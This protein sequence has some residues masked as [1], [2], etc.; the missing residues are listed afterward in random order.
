MFCQL[1]LSWLLWKIARTEFNIHN[2]D[3]NLEKIEYC[4][5]TTINDQ[6]QLRDFVNTRGRNFTFEKSI[7]VL[8]QEF[9]IY[10]LINSS[11]FKN[12][13]HS[14]QVNINTSSTSTVDTTLKR[15]NLLSQCFDSEVNVTSQSSD[16]Y[17]GIND[18]LA[19]DFSHTGSDNDSS[20]DID[21]LL[22]R[23]QQHSFPILSS[24]AKVV[25]AI[26]AS[27]TT[28]ERLSSTAKNVVTEK[29]TRLHCEKINQM[30]FLQKNMNILKELLNSDFRRKRT[31]SMSSTTTVS[32]EESTC[33]V[34]KQLCLDVVDSFNDANKENILD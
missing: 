12:T 34:P 16:P 32:S 28:I 20:D 25:C 23:Q 26:P 7:N 17:Q 11:S 31:A 22:W 6:S 1:L 5:G 9:E 4:L 18:Y 24:M 15:K 2:T 14:I 33:T 19:A 27:N 13:L 3:E 29:I 21:L 8:K 10:E 30:L